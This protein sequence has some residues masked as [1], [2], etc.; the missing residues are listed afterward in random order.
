[1]QLCISYKKN[2]MHKYASVSTVSL[3]HILNLKS[4]G[5]F[6]PLGW[7]Q[8]KRNYIKSQF[9]FCLFDISSVYKGF[10]SSK[11]KYPTVSKL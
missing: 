10:F 6:S 11:Q 3:C 5:W 8:E 7:L 4:G 1:M 2:V 9:A